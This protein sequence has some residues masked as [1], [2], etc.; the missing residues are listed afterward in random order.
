MQPPDECVGLWN[1][2]V[3]LE[4]QGDRRKALAVL[5]SFVRGIKL[6]DI[7]IQVEW[8]RAFLG[9]KSLSALR[10]PIRSPLFVEVLFPVLRDGFNARDKW[11]IR[12]LAKLD[13]HLYQAKGCWAELGHPTAEGLW[14]IAHRLDPEDEEARQG[15]VE[16][17][18]NYIR[19]TLHEVPSGV[20]FGA[21]GATIPECLELLELLKEF[22]SICTTSERSSF[23]DLIAKAELHYPG[24]L[25]YVKQLPLIQ[26]YDSFLKV[27]RRP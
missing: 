27:R 5:R 22:T 19:Y 15:L 12:W 11:A 23:G 16:Q 1:E 24:Y 10:V 4:T 18:A 7:G 25:E 8:V 26:G 20:L 3:S 14:R 13:Q 17:I 21:D 6:L 2:Y 9:T